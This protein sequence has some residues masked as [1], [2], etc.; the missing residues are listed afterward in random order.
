LTHT[1]I[2]D[3][4]GARGVTTVRAM[5]IERSWNFDPSRSEQGTLRLYVPRDYP[6]GYAPGG[7]IT[8]QSGSGTAWTL[9]LD[10]ANALN[11]RW[12]Q[13]NDGKVLQHF[14]LNDYIRVA[15]VNDSGY[16]EVTG[17]ITGT[18]DADAGTVAVT[19]DAT[20]TPSTHTWNLE[21][22]NDTGSTA[23]A[24]QRKYAYVADSNRQLADGS[25]ARRFA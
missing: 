12:S 3:G 24:S 22:R 20:W 15:R 23:S 19:F 17:T 14:Q 8:S 1:L 11:Q 6:I 18:P 9:T 13:A 25:F 5:V 10:V 2:P 7:R 4:A 21:Y 16:T